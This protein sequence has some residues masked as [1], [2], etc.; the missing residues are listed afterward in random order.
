M[1]YHVLA[2]GKDVPAATATSDASGRWAT[3]DLGLILQKLHMCPLI[4][5]EFQQEAV[6]KA[7]AARAAQKA[8][9]EAAA[10]AAAAEAENQEA[11][12]QAAKESL[13]SA[14]VFCNL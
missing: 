2:C 13:R 10:K 5:L 9:E 6:Q 8:Q 14:V 12:R 7:I 1:D 11:A 3:Q 4:V